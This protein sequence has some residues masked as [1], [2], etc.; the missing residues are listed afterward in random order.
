[1][2]TSYPLR[3]ILASIFYVLRTDCP[4]RYLPGNFS[5]GQPVFYH[6]RRF[7]RT[8]TWHLLYAYTRP[9]IARNADVYSSAASISSRPE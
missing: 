4:W 3:H 9:C 7:R 5:P 8:A 1:M 6:F 2:C